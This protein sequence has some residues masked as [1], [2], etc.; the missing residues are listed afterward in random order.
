MN[1]SKNATVNEMVKANKVI[2]LA[3]SSSVDIVFP[4]MKSLNDL[5]IKVFTDAS[6]R[7]LPDG[8]SQGGHVV[9]LTDG[10]RSCPVSWH[11]QKIKRIVKSTIAA[12]TLALADGC[13]TAYG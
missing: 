3:Q 9:F 1:S 2:K 6:F 11:S 7:N 10:V 13:E 4:K 8:G 5:Y 12:E